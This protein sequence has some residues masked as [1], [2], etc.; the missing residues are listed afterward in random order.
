MRTAAFARRLAVAAAVA[1]PLALAAAGTATAATDP[2]D[3]GYGPPQSSSFG[4]KTVGPVC[5][6]NVPYL[7]WTIDLT[8]VPDATGLTITWINPDGDDIVMSGLPLSGSVRWP[9]ATVDAAGQPTDWP[10]WRWENGTWVQ[11]DGYDWVRPTVQ[12]RFTVDESGAAGAAAT[13]AGTVGNAAYV[14]PAGA[15]VHAA[16]ALRTALEAVSTVSYPPATSA[17][18]NP[19]PTKVTPTGSPTT[20]G[21]SPTGGSTTTSPAGG[22]TTTSPAGGGGSNGGGSNGGGSNG[23]GSNGGSLAQ[24]GASVA[25]YAGG[26]LA[27]VVVGGGLVAVARRRRHEG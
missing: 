1:A 14:R 15:T 24:T 10:G 5:D 18:A 19:V 7:R 20:A 16:P 27:L 22:S 12:V 3:G 8:N 17:C 4:V 11:G 2:S 25:P 23:G 13:S 9:G 21:P 6:G 26:A